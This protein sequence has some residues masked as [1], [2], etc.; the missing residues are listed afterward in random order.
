MNDK[1]SL[2]LE[3]YQLNAHLNLKNRIV[4]APMTRNMA[5]NDFVPIDDMAEYYA[6]R[7]DAGLIITEGTIIEPNARGYS[8]TPGIYTAKQ[9]D[10]WKKVVDAVHAQNGLIFLQLWHVGR[11]SHPAFLNGNLPISAS[12]TSMTGILPRSHLPLGNS[13]AACVNEIN[14]MVNSFA[15]AAE[16]AIQAGFDGVEIHGANGYLIDQFLHYHTNQ[17]DDVYGGCPENMARFPLEIVVACGEA[18]G[19]ERVGLRISPGTYFNEIVGDE[20]DSLVFKCL[21]E[22]L[23]NL[24]IAYVHT[25][26]DNDSVRFKELNNM[27]MTSF[28]RS[29]YEGNLIACGGYSFETAM[30]GITSNTFDLVAMGK[31]FIANPDLIRKAHVKAQLTAYHVNMLNTL[32]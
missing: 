25:G 12:V 9:I 18:I 26:N 21:L 24:K 30:Q 27:T 8:N 2:L 10:G 5:D 28:I 15:Q 32:Y 1:N 20:R 31:P 16:N 23:N 22:R 19:F 4:M 6:R 3:N 29:H 13:R 14:E 11:V 17:R 7:A